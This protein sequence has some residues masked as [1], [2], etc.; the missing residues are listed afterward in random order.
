MSG[1][2]FSQLFHASVLA[3]SPG[4]TFLA[5]AHLNR[6]VV[7][8]TASL[9][10]VRTWACVKPTEPP[11]AASSSRQG[12]LDA[13]TLASGSTSS[14]SEE[15]LIDTLAFSSDSLYL[16]V[17]SAQA[18]M[19]WVYGLAEE[20]EAARIGGNGV[21]GLSSVE[22]GRGSREVLAW[23]DLGLRLSIYNLSTGETKVIQYPKSLHCH[24]YSPDARYLAVA[25]KHLGKEHVGIY[26]VLDEYN[27]IRH[28]PLRTSDIQ[29]LLWSPC[30]KYIAAWDTP[31]SY[32][33]YV[34]SPLGPLLTHFSSTSPTFSPSEDPGLG[35]RT[36]AW[37]PGGRWIALGGWDGK[38]RIVESD[39]WRCV[40]TIGW[41]A[42]PSE[43]EAT[44]WKEPNDWLKD[45]RGRGI[46]Q[47]DRLPLP[48][49][50]PT[51]RPDLTKPSPKTGVSHLSFDRDGSL[52]FVRLEHQPNIIHI[53]TFLP[54]PTA[55]TPNITHAASLLFT[56]PVRSAAWCP[57][58]DDQEGPRGR[59]LAVVTRGGAVYFWDGDGG[60]VEE[61]GEEGEDGDG[62]LEVGKG[63]MM[64][65]VG[66]PSRADFSA[67]DLQW[68]PDGKSLA[69]QDK[70]QFCLLYDGDAVVDGAEGETS[71]LMWDGTDE[72]LTHVSE[73][74]EE[75]DVSWSGGYSGELGASTES[76]RY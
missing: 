45:T 31:L 55:E 17:Y 3:F 56:Y 24:T 66:I 73:A 61:D 1:Y 33:L 2:E 37:A 8:S 26:D 42:R 4:T 30:G 47:F 6:I 46:V 13:S 35:V 5:T 74:D 57:G 76:S 68:S 28:F 58:G 25:E 7:R 69:I 49:G 21:E 23:S 59:K 40:G 70:T 19:A 15:F 16:L 44:V 34:H 60:W 51:A 14:G 54:T 52:L 41:G 20:G 22:W 38:V 63:G 65:G 62:Q 36:A 64:E 32:S 9:Q 10:I 53:H 12:R 67:L 48:A 27:L 29:G 71:Q 18:K 11:V 75:G 72:G 50:F 39:G 43:R